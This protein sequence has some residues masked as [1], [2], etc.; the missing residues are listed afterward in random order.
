MQ[1]E[2]LAAFCAT[3]LHMHE[4]LR[5]PV[6]D[7][8]LNSTVAAAILVD[9]IAAVGYTT[10]FEDKATSDWEIVLCQENIARLV[11]LATRTDETGLDHG[12]DCIA[13]FL[14][15]RQFS[16]PACCVLLRLFGRGFLWGFFFFLFSFVL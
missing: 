4:E 13:R 6:A 15:V 1:D 11:A 3:T 8:A 10:Y 12:I 7:L 14:D 9:L 2:E 16:G 5:A